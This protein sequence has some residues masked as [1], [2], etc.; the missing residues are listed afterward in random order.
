MTQVMAGLDN[1]LAAA[2]LLGRA[3][4]IDMEDM[5]MD[6]LMAVAIGDMAQ[7]DRSRIVVQRHTHTRTAA[8]DMSLMRLAL[9]NLLSNALK[10]GTPSTPVVI[11]LADSD[12][13]L[14]LL[15]DVSGSG[16]QISAQ[17]LPT[18]FQRGPRDR[19]HHGAPVGMGLGL[20]IVKR[21]MELH[22]GRVELARND[23]D[24][25][26]MRL[27]LTPASA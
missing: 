8:M 22:G 21:V 9:R 20:Y 23:A 13:P 11:T 27:L 16:P 1:T 10:Y 17:V 6:T 24:G 4:P 26:T 12:D 18:L 15:I 14:G 2:A 3:A 19:P 5:D 7:D 25:V